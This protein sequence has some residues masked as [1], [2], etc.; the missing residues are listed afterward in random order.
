MYG[1]GNGPPPPFPGTP[2]NLPPFPPTRPPNPNGAA[3]PPPGGF[4]PFRPPPQGFVPPPFPPNF[5]PGSR[6]PPTMGGPGG[7]MPIRPGGPPPGSGGGGGMPP[8]RPPPSG[9]GGPGGYQ[10]RP[11]HPGLGLPPL[12]NG[13]PQPPRFQSPNGI[14]GSPDV[15]TTSVFVGSIAPG[16]GDDTLRDLLNACGPLHELKRVVGASGKPQA[17]GFASFENPEVVLRA[18]RCLNG[19]ELPD[20][21]PEGRGQGKPAKKLVVKADQKTQEFLEEFEQTLGRSDNDEEADAVC[22]KSVQHIVALLTDPNAAPP[23]GLKPTNGGSSPLQV[24]VPAHLQDLKEGDLPEEQRVVVLDQIA[25]FREN[26]AKRERE[27]K[28]MEEEKERF[29]AMQGG[30]GGRGQQGGGTTAYGYGNRGLGKMQQQAEMRQ[31]GG[32]Q[33]QLGG[34]S[35][36]HQQNGAGPSKARD[37]QAYDKP[38]GFV[39]AQ[40][41]ESKVD[42][43]RTDE[44]EEELRRQRRQ[45][46]KDVALRDA[47]RRVENRERGRIEALNR[48]LAH[49][50]AQADLIERTRRRQEEQYETWDD[51]E[52]A[53]KGRELFYADRAQW[54]ARRGKLRM[55]EY[56]DDVRDRQ[57]EED[58]LKALERESEE[59]LKKQLAEMAEMEEQQR[60]RGLLTE[61]AAPIKLDIKPVLMSE[62]KPKN[63]NEEKKPSVAPSKKPG[64]AFGDDDDDLD[65]SGEKKKKRT[66]VKL[67]FDGEMDGGLTEAE[68][69]AKRNARLLE[70]RKAIPGDKR[71]LWASEIDWA[72]VGESTIRDKIQPFVHEKMVDLLGELDQDLADFVLEHLRDRRGADDLVEGLEPV[73]AEDAESFVVQLWKQLVFESAAFKAGL[74]TGAM[75]A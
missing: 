24:I 35:P 7:G 57:L 15:K 70:I 29:K 73:L 60:A 58:E 32:G 49:R 39:R 45:R 41:A 51:D 71:S 44:E 47:E 50:K 69:I 61:D 20:L 4:P 36:N 40:A 25:I 2:G 26:A 13:L 75:M 5:A 37:P 27:K 43:D 48:E 56:Q 52:I 28:L 68:K 12:P 33:Q 72:A 8:F 55:R 16:I 1:N 63:P 62:I 66:F 46:D 34:P 53:E 30:Q 21:S 31:W 3:I 74:E 11:Q 23:D 64:V 14:P 54:R 38:V 10:P 19:V 59:F 65:E 22:R 17:F 42:S 18:I 6:P 67:D 9:P